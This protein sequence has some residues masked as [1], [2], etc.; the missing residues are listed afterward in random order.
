MG[1]VSQRVGRGVEG[2]G[3]KRDG[4]TGGTEKRGKEEK[5][6]IEKRRGT[7]VPARKSPPFAQNA[8]DGAPSNTLLS[9]VTEANLRERPHP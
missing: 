6:R 2:N 9:G 5:E 3:E 7:A 4:N 1:E 8:K